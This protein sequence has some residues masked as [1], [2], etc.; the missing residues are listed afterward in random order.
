MILKHVGILPRCRKLRTLLPAKE[1]NFN[2]DKQ[3]KLT[4]GA[5]GKTIS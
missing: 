4:L 3:D 1:A 5:K 2:Q